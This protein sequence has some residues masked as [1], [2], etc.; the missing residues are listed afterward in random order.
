MNLTET[1][2]MKLT[3]EHLAAY[4]P[5]G[6]K[7]VPIYGGYAM[8]DAENIGR[9]L[10][11]DKRLKLILRPL[12]DLTREI[13]HNGEKF[14]PLERIKC[15]DLQS[16]HDWITTGRNYWINKFG[17]NKWLNRTPFGIIVNIHSWHFD[18]FGLIDA[19]LAIDINTLKNA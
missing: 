12:S 4:L 17:R 13:T 8:L 18:T 10:G 1:K 7:V 11:S 15:S 5:Y 6:V 3:I 2:T 9:I 14:V 19:G 16:H